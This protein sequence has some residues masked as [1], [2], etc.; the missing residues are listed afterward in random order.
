[1]FDP[2]ISEYYGMLRP[3]GVV[4]GDGISTASSFH[5]FANCR[6]E[7]YEFN[8]SKDPSDELFSEYWKFN[9]IPATFFWYNYACDY[10]E[11]PEYITHIGD[12]AFIYSKF[13]T[14]KFNEGLKSIG[15][16][17]F[18][19]FYTPSGE[20]TLPSTVETI[21]YGAFSYNY[22]TNVYKFDF[23]RT[24]IT[25]LESNMFTEDSEL[26]EILL[27]HT[28]ES[29]KD[30]V[31]RSCWSLRRITCLSM[32]APTLSANSFTNMNTWSSLSSFLELCVPMGATGYDTG[33]WKTQLLDKGWKLRYI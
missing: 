7:Y 22:G 25:V 3:V 4:I 15:S 32:T 31:C 23:S 11:I 16:G 1:M 8:P 30:S 19:C 27:P 24:K 29:I 6:V 18:Q 21:G 26:Q 28:L 2:S 5:E 9:K 17:A 12:S 10:I 33:E 13:N 20:L 14:I